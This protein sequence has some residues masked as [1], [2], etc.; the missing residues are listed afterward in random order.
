MFDMDMQGIKVKDWRYFWKPKTDVY[1]MSRHRRKII[2]PR[3]V[4]HNGNN[5]INS[6]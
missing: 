2:A 6:I 5:N 1:H 3:S 4:H